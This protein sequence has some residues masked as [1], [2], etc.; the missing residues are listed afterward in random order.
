MNEIL[1]DNKLQT[2]LNI[3]LISIDFTE[4]QFQSSHRQ[5]KTLKRKTN[6]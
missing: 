3:Q 1:P 2:L 4:V 6:A 5:S